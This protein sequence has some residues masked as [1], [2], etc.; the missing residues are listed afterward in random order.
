MDK[1]GLRLLGRNVEEEGG[2]EAVGGD[3]VSVWAGNNDGEQRRTE[4][5]HPRKATGSQ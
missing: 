1:V 5:K 4:S 2:K 3:G